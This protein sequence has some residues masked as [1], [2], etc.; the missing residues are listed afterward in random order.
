MKLAAPETAPAGTRPHAP[1]SARQ[2]DQLKW[3]SAD[4]RL[5]RRLAA[6]LDDIDADKTVD[7]DLALVQEAFDTQPTA[8]APKIRARADALSAVLNR[9][10]HEIRY[11]GLLLDADADADADATV[12][13]AEAVAVSRPCDPYATLRRRAVIAEALLDLLDI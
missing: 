4:E 11:R 9:R 6:G 7:A 13:R 2:I 12:Q 3:A 10:T 5:L 8:P 1:Q